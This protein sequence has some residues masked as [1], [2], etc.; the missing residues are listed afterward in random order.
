MEGEGEEEGEEGRKL[1][2][3]KF[4]E[5][6]TRSDSWDTDSCDGRSENLLYLLY[7]K[8]LSH[9]MDLALYWLLSSGVGVKFA[10]FSNQWEG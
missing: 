6:L 2:L 3:N 4:Y 8:G 9:E 10:Q 5:D 7:L 1:K